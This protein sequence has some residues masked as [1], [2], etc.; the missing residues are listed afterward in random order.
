MFHRITGPCQLIAL[1]ASLAV[2]TVVVAASKRF[3]LKDS[4]LSIGGKWALNGNYC[5]YRD[6]ASDGSCKPSYENN[7]I[8]ESLK[9]GISQ[10]EVFFHLGMPES[11]HGD[12]YVFTSGGGESKIRIII[13]KG[14]VRDLQCKT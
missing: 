5:I 8:C 2:A 7:L 3:L 13:K 4:C 10:D 11:S 1:L 14:K 6:C 12:I 9:P